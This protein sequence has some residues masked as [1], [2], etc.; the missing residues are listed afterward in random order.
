[1]KANEAYLDWQALGPQLD[2]LLAAIERLDA[3]AARDV[4]RSLVV[5]FQPMS[6]L[7]DHVAIA[8]RD[9]APFPSRPVVSIAGR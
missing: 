1:M 9:V 8:A 2:R 4:L 7:V 5:D 6:D 3:A